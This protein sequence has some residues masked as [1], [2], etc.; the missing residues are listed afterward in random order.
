MRST[1]SFILRHPSRWLAVYLL[2]LGIAC[3]WPYNFF[4]ENRVSV[5]DG[6]IRFSNPGTAFTGSPVSLPQGGGAFSLL[7]RYTCRRPTENAW[8]THWGESMGRYTILVGQFSNQ[9]LVDLSTGPDLRRSRV[10]VQG[11]VRPDTAVWLG[12]VYDG[13]LLEVYC[14]GS[15][16]GAAVVHAVAEGHTTAAYPLVLGSHANGKFPWNGEMDAFALFGRALTPEELSRPEA[17]LRE[18]DP[19]LRFDFAAAAGGIVPDGGSAATP[20]ALIIPAR[21]RPAALS[22]LVPPQNYWQRGPLYRDILANV[23][24]FLPFGVLLAALLHG[25]YRPWTI[26]VMVLLISCAVSAAIE[27]LQAILPTRWSSLTD[28]LTNTVGGG[29]GA[30]AFVLGWLPPF[31]GRTGVAR[32]TATPPKTPVP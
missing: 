15:R 18:G 13:A 7:L 19:L 12:V 26:T 25:R 20:T 3:L 10:F 27:L 9:I 30:L 32:S 14:D 17:L 16:K 22:P 11:Q 23:V 21:F 5:R 31:A 4:Q 1:Q 6:A 2:L 29:L 28:L 8:I 24:L